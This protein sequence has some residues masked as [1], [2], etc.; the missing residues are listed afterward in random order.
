MISSFKFFAK[1]MRALMNNKL[2][3]LSTEVHQ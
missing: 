3:L 1:F 2:F